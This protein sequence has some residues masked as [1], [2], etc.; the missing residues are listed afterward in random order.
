MKSIYNLWLFIACLTLASCYNEDTIV[1]ATGGESGRF[2]FPQGDNSWDKDILDIYEQ[3]GIRFIYKDIIEKDF[4]KSWLA[5][6]T[7]NKSFHGGGTI[8][9]DMT[10][11]YVIF[12]KNHVLQYL[13]PQVT[14]KIF[15]M[16]WYLAFN[17]Y[18]ITVYTAT[19]S[20]YNQYKSH[21]DLGM[22]DCWIT[23][24]WGQNVPTN[25]EPLA[26]W[27]SP[28]AGDKAS[29]TR[30]RMIIL[31]DVLVAAINRGNIVM[32]AEFESG[33]DFTTR[34]VT[35]ETVANR[36]DPNYYMRRGFPGRVNTSSGEYTKPTTSVTKAEQTF[37]Y[38]L[39]LSMRYTQEEREEMF[40]SAD[41]P[42]TK[43]KFDYVQKYMK[44]TYNIDLSAIANG[45]ATWDISPYPELPP[46][47]YF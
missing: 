34:L 11:F 47:I 7:S 4:T 22:M 45:P 21:A 41:Y 31:N 33:F 26:A 1:S 17:F 2:D 12:M 6:A 37:I 20:A 19:Y 43:S 9:D 18:S 15:P 14:E 32:P 38:Y 46:A 13:N 35:G 28:K 27:L 3:F 42:F 8:S 23:C 29:F 25:K 39:Q 36:A 30:R 16:Y 24:F 5:G 40:P 10:R 44:D